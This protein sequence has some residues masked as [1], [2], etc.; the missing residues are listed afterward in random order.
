MPNLPVKPLVLMHFDNGIADPYNDIPI[1]PINFGGPVTNRVFLKDGASVQNQTVYFD[2]TK[3]IEMQSSNGF[4]TSGSFTIKMWVNLA[5]YY[6]ATCLFTSSTQAISASM[7]AGILFGYMNTSLGNILYLYVSSNGTSWNE[8]SQQNLGPIDYNE[9]VHWEIDYDAATRTLYVFKNGLLAYS[10]QLSA[11]PYFNTSRFSGMSYPYNTGLITGLI[12]DFNFIPGVCE[13]TTNF[14]PNSSHSIEATKAIHPLI[15]DMQSKFGNN[16][17]Y[18]NGSSFAYFNGTSALSDTTKDFTVS[19]WEYLISAPSNSC[20][21]VVDMDV[22]ISAGA[23]IILGH[24]N[25][26]NKYIYAT[27]HR[28]TWDLV[29]AV[30]IDTVANCLNKWVHWEVGYKASTKTLYFFKDGILKHSVV[31]PNPVYVDSTLA[32]S[33]GTY[34]TV[35]TA[36]FDEFLILSGSCLH[37]ENFTPPTEPYTYNRTTLQG[38]S[39]SPFSGLRSKDIDGNLLRPQQGSRELKTFEGD[40]INPYP[41]GVRSLRSFAGNR[42]L[43]YSGAKEQNTYMGNKLSIINSSKNIN[44]FCGRLQRI[45]FGTRRNRRFNG[46]LSISFT[47]GDRSRNNQG[48]LVSLMKDSNA[49]DHVKLIVTPTNTYFGSGITV[50]AKN[51]LYDIGKYRLFLNKAIAIPYL[52]DFGPVDQ[53]SFPLDVSLLPLGSTPC[54]LE[55]LFPDGDKEYIDFAVT[56]EANNRQA[57]VTTMYWY[58]GGFDMIGESRYIT[59]DGFKSGMLAARRSDKNVLIVTTDITSVDLSHVNNILGINIECEASSC[60]FLVSFDGRNTWYSLFNGIWI[61]C[62]LSNIATQGMLKSVFTSIS[63]TK[64]SEIFQKTRL[65]VAVFL[66]AT[67]LLPEQQIF[68][69]TMDATLGNTATLHAVADVPAGYKVTSM[70]MDVTRNNT[71]AFSGGSGAFVPWSGNGYLY[72]QTGIFAVDRSGREIACSAGGYSGTTAVVPADFDAIQLVTNVSPNHGSYGPG[73][74]YYAY[75]VPAYSWIKS[76]SVL[77]VPNY[78]PVLSDIDLLPPET[79]TDSI[80]SAH[81]KDAEGDPAYYQVSINGEPMTE[82]FITEGTEYDIAITIPSSMTAVGTNAITI[83]TFDGLTYGSYTTYLTKIDAKPAISG[84]LDKLKFTALITDADSGDTVRYRIL[85]NG[86]V[87]VDWTDFAQVPR[88]VRY[89]MRNRDINIGVQNTLTL[90]AE[91]N[92]GEITS[93]DFDFVGQLYNLKSRYSYIL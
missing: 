2:G 70:R 67:A 21:F 23:G 6:G 52:S 74:G 8:I 54:R 65:D 84:I 39:I 78:P 48:I 51:N 40:A 22:N 50:D 85:L 7:C 63:D 3:F 86:V 76:L 88:N 11:N 79:H 87:K 56:K 26:S 43:S 9:W 4:D 66:S 69:K 34:A 91:D 75:G 29:N 49:I 77:F 32:C 15:S 45:G 13:H 46:D 55:Y 60:L 38:Q 42:I 12:A 18:I 58:S 89:T 16:S 44:T 90:E 83:Q 64:W 62:E 25:G 47:K 33:L 73:R 71:D 53:I 93:V 19:V 5:G 57:A 61:E 92:L 41:P 24:V 81:I 68:Y 1:Q 14:T 37:T 17:Y 82:E 30:V 36:Y 35:E 28:S 72:Y 31:C 20:T 80:L 59:D 10:K 27:S